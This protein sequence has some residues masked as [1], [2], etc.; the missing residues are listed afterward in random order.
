MEWSSWI[1]FSEVDR[2]HIPEKPGVYEI[3]CVSGRGKPIEIYRVY[4][5]DEHGILSIGETSNLS[6]RLHGFRRT[7]QPH[8]KRSSHAAGYYYVSLG[9]SRVFK[10]E[11][12]QFKYKVTGTK[13]QAQKEEFIL[14]CKYRSQFLDLPPL[15]NNLGKY[16]RRGWKKIMKAI[17]GIEPLEG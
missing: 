6:D 14:L 10:K 8:T 2:Y 5:V 4:G 9:Y 13:K 1:S 12:L 7:I 17:T 3:R 16:P 11:N 15:N